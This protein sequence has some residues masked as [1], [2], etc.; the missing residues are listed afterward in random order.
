MPQIGRESVSQDREWC[1]VLQ[2][3]TCRRLRFHDYHEIYK[4]PGLYEL[5]FYDCLKCCSPSRVV[6]LLAEVLHEAEVPPSSLRVL[7]IGAGNGMV[8]EELRGKGIPMVVGLDIIPEAKEATERDRP[9]VYAEYLVADLTTLGHK[10]LALL[11]KQRLNCLTSVA[12]LG[13]GDI[14]PEAFLQALEL[15]EVQGWLAFNI[16]ED[17]LYRRDRTGFCKLIRR[18]SENE[19]I[20]IQAYRRYRHRFSMNGEGLYYVAMVAQKMQEVRR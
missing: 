18:L 17:F 8:G 16:K 11:Q 9:D 15:V 10:D 3:G 5:L 1:E 2:G 13:F 20:R 6:G 12:A 14:P 7:D 4:I 19:T